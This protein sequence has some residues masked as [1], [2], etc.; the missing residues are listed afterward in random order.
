MNNLKIEAPFGKYDDVRLDIKRYAFDDSLA[1]EAISLS[2][3]PV[4]RLTVC[5]ADKNLEPYE[6]YVDTN[7]CPW[8]LELIVNNQLGQVTGRS[9]MSGYCL[10]PSVKFDL[11]ELFRYKY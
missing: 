3:G 7:N 4:A 11:K 5:L 9:R 6:S 8:A 2:E 1:I 10:Y